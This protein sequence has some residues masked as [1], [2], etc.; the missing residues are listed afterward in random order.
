MF[1]LLGTL[2]GQTD[3]QTD[4]QTDGQYWQNN[5]A[6]CVQCMLIADAL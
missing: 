1:V 2:D 3:R 4:R 6:L 5:I